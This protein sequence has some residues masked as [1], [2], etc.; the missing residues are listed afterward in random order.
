V[1]FFGGVF[2]FVWVGW[3]GGGGVG[4]GVFFFCWVLLGGV[5]GLW[6]VFF[7]GVVFLLFCVMGGFGFGGVLGVLGWGGFFVH[8]RETHK[9]D[10]KRGE[11]R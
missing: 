3:C 10:I 8:D 11:G 2:F 1:G 9:E 5:F 7:G 6:G 4:L